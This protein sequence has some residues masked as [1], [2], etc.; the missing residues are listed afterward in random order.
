MLMDSLSVCICASIFLKLSSRQRSKSRSPTQLPSAFHSAD[1][2]LKRGAKAQ[3]QNG[4]RATA[5][6]QDLHS[7]AV[8]PAMQHQ[9]LHTA[10]VWGCVWRVL[11]LPCCMPFIPLS[12]INARGFEHKQHL[13]KMLLIQTVAF[14]HAT[15]TW[16]VS[17]CP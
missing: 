2:S 1:F 11:T 14:V 5:A 7:I 9:L 6:A 4:P 8:L 16:Q 10:S 15:R 17:Q 3:R 13:S 12:S